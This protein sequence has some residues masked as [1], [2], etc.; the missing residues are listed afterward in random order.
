MTISNAIAGRVL[1]TLRAAIIG[2][3]F[4]P[5]MARCGIGL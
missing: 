5:E 1:E 2:E 4:A 3:V